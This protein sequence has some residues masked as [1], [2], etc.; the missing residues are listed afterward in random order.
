MVGMMY[1]YWKTKGIWPDEFYNKPL[2]TRVLLAAFYEKE[3]E[4][5]VEILKNENIMAVKIV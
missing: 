4:E 2:G 1:Y 3:L 5:K